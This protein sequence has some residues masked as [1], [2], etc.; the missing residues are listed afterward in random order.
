MQCWGS[1]ANGRL[2]DNTNMNRTRPT[3]VMALGGAATQV[4]CGD[5][6]TCALLSDGAVR[7]W[8]H[9]NEDQ[10]G[11]G[12][13]VME[14]RTPGSVADLTDATQ[15]SAGRDFASARPAGAAPR[16]AGG[17]TTTDSSAMARPRTARARCGS[18]T[19]GVVQVAAASDH[20][21]ARL[22]DGTVRCWGENNEDQLGDGTG[23]QRLSPVT[24]TGLSGV[25]AV[26]L[27]CGKNQCCV[28]LADGLVRCWGD[29]RATGGF[30]DGTTSDRNVATA[31]PT[32]SNVRHVTTRGGHSCSL[33]GG[34]ARCW[35]L[36]GGEQLGDGSTSQRLSPVLVRW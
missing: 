8:G 29:N 35:G 15:I 7:C 11:D 26:A 23:T 1:N 4:S 16:C 24:V 21:C 6:F 32:L 22:A 10:L 30:G 14:R 19:Q 18:G 28:A 27:A 20:A 33:G 36:N 2:G 12:S 17:A 34:V 3:P 25:R 13:T 5:S 9:N 31:V